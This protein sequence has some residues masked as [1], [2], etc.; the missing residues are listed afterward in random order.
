MQYVKVREVLYV[1]SY[2]FNDQWFMPNSKGNV[3][4]LVVQNNPR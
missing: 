2:A 3:E 4:L 1:D